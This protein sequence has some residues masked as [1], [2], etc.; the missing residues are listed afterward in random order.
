MEFHKNLLNIGF[1]VSTAD[2]CVYVLRT[3]KD[4][5]FLKINT[6][7]CFSIC[8]NEELR[9]SVVKKLQKALD[10]KDDGLMTW[11][12]GMGIHQYADRIEVEQNDFLQSILDEYPDTP[13]RDVPMKP[14]LILRPKKAEEGEAGSGE[15]D[16]QR[17]KR[18][19]SKK[20]S[21]SLDPTHFPYRSLC[22][23]LRYLTV[24]RYDFEYALNQLCK[25]QDNPGEEHV[26]AMIY[27]IGYLRKYPKFS[28]VYRKQLDPADTSFIIQGK[29]DHHFDP[30]FA[31]GGESDASF[32]DC[33]ETRRS[34]Y[35][36]MVRV[37][38][39]PV[40]WKSRRT[41][42]VATGTVPAEYYALNYC[43][44]SILFVRNILT[45]LSLK[46][47]AMSGIRSD[48]RGVID[49]VK[50]R[51]LTEH[52]KHLE[53]YFYFVKEQYQKGTILPEYV[54]SKDNFADIFTKPL[55]PV[56]FNRLLGNAQ[57][58]GKHRRGDGR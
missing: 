4:F 15:A 29:T 47:E 46:T 19:K 42:E 5:Y 45:S 20:S 3:S 56:V 55:P 38:G 30:S 21:S 28:L 31:V 26:Q 48:S 37:N 25:Y 18:K 24:T 2:P 17:K 6:D 44:R 50:L 10:Y 52:T 33:K 43:T 22:G 13:F 12:L 9:L 16:K 1:K 8:T 14:H 39:C 57:L 54:A 7:D 34:T 40:A 35:G 49:T 53:A 27:L 36:Y 11:H 23:K 51:R 32:A 41:P 58:E